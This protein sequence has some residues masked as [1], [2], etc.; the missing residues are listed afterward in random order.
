MSEVLIENLRQF[1]AGDIL[2]QPGRQIRPDEPLISSG[3]VDSFSLIDLSLYVQDQYQV[4]LDDTELT[5]ETFD[6][7]DQLAA[8][9]RSRMK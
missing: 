2:K 8:L 9:I 5:A 7:L 1:I 3:L 6:T 4:Q